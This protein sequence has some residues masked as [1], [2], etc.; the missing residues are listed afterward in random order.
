MLIDELKSIARENGIVGAGG[1]GFPAY[2]KMTE[3]ADTVILNCVECEP[4]LK[5]HRQL[6]ATHTKEIITML[7]EI[8]E[9]FG[10]KEAVVGIKNEYKATIDALNEILPDFPKVR[11]CGL[12]AAYPMGDEVVLIYEATG[13]VIRAGGLPIEE[14]V[15]VYNVETMYNLYRAVHLNIPVTNKLVSIVG[16]IDRPLTV[17]VPL[18][19]TVREAI[20]LA[21]HVSC[22]DPAYLMGG[23]MMGRLGTENTVITKTTNAIIILPKDHPVIAKMNKNLEI[24]R[25]RASSA[26]CQCRTCTD[27]CP[28]H[29]LGHPIEPH[30]VM[31][32]VA[33]AD[34]S[35]LSVYMNTAFCSGCGVCE[36]YA[37]PQGLSPKSIIQNLKGGLRGAG[38]KV[39]PVES[40]GVLEDREL[41]KVPVHRLAGRLGLSQ[42][43]VEAPFIDT[44]PTTA[45]V[46]IQMSQHIGAPAIPLVS[47]GEAVKKGQKI[48]EA[49]EGLSVSIHCS[50]DGIV[51]EVSDKEIVVR[52][53]TVTNG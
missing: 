37:C 34:T 45:Y 35:D 17:R 10:A 23:P 3:K 31:R 38:I 6:L 42:Y 25:K 43:D 24:E 7:D 20:A 2:A 5:L 50:I 32:A 53:R 9:A 14:N 44:T 33:N 21:G 4:L 36:K 47:V 22:K 19:T 18:G 30:K 27:M 51:E 8:R 40:T 28:R 13:R 15:V 12:R 11:I 52:E 46:R 49:A 1:A 41:R 39:E 48:A 16:E 29:A 26:C